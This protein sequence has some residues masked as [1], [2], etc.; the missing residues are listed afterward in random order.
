MSKAKYPTE[1]L[2]CWNKAKEIR[3]NYY[4]NYAQ[5]HDKGGLRWAGGAWSLGAIPAGLGDD[6]YPITG[7][8]YGASIA[9][10]KEFSIRC[11][12]AAES[13]GYAR[14]L[15]SYM[16]S[17]WG[18][19]ILNEYAFGG[20]FPKPDFMWQDHICC[21]HAK[22]YQVASELEGGVPV[23]CIDAAAGPYD[24][25]TENRIN[26]LV[27]QMH[28]GIAWLEKTTGRK[29][30]D[31]K[32]IEAVHNECDATSTWAEICALNKAVPA[33]LEEK[34]MYALYV[35]GT[36]MKHS[37]IVADFYRELL[38]EVKDRVK[39]GIAAVPNERCRVMSDTQPPWGFLKI[40]RY[41]EKFGC[42]SIGSLYTFG[43][44]GVWE[45][46]PDGT[47]GPRTTP[48]QKGLKIENRDQALRILADWNLSKPEW[49][50]F[51]SPKLKSEMMIRI[52]KEWK[53][54]GILLHYNR[55]CEG[56][57]LGIAENRLALQKAGYPV[58]T[59]EGNMG[60]ERE[61]DESRTT[62]RIDS[63]M[64]TLGLK[65]LE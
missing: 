29:Y 20:P 23:F 6:V 53:L 37:K 32:L 26:Y 25:V 8:P 10:N 13:K 7:E 39:R 35:L 34:S 3:E 43:L 41:M 61:F 51:Y 52:A 42:V 45:V 62:A 17:Y 19:I 38:D 27:N 11:M 50:H 64:E 49:Q 55:G 16:R 63:F 60:D 28:D 12:E 48:R 18:S 59:F 65:K 24:E 30:S 47:W 2:K 46:K 33:P 58:M 1:Q 56:L 9:F 40:F 5:A 36:L 14:D 22:W 15:C 54:D 21:S 44:I 31:E 57:S 4:K